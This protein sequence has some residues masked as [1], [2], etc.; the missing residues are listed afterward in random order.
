MANADECEDVHYSAPLVPTNPY[1]GGGSGGGGGDGGTCDCDPT[2]GSYPTST[3]LSTDINGTTQVTLASCSGLSSSDV[4]L[5]ETLIY[6]GNGTVGRVIA[7]NSGKLTV[8][9]MTTAGDGAGSKSD[10]SY[11][12]TSTL[13]TAFTGTTN[14][15]QSSVTGLSPA[16]VVLNETLIFDGNGTVG[17]VIGISGSNYIVQT[18]SISPGER[19]GTRLGSVEK[20]TNLPT[21]CAAAVSL[22]WQT[23]ISGDFAYVR[24]YNGHLAEFVAT[25]DDSCNITWQWS[26]DLNAGDYLTGVKDQKGNPLPIDGDGMVTLPRE[27]DGTYHSNTALN[28]AIGGTRNIA[29]SA[30]DIAAVGD[31]VLDETLI[32]DD[33]GTVG[34]V[35]AVSGT[36][37]T[38][39]TITVAGDGDASDGSYPTTATLDL[40]IA[41][42]TTIG[43]GTISGIPPIAD[44]VLNETL[45]YDAAGTLGRV[46]SVNASANTV[47]VETMTTAG[48]QDTVSDG[49]YATT[50]TLDKTIGNTQTLNLSDTAIANASDIMPGETLLFDAKGTMARVDSISGTGVITATTV[51]TAGVSDGTYNTSD[52]LENKVGDVKTISASNIT[53]ISLTDVVIG[54]TL[55][56]DNYG[57]VGKVVAVNTAA[58]TVDVETITIGVGATTN[59]LVGGWFYAEGQDISYAGGEGGSSNDGKANYWML[60]A[61]AL[62]DH[63]GTLRTAAMTVDGN[64]GQSSSNPDITVVELPGPALYKVD[65]TM[66]GSYGTTDS[67]AKVF[68]SENGSVWKFTGV[69]CKATGGANSMKKENQGSTQVFIEVPAGK[70]YYVGYA[71]TRAGGQCLIGKCSFSVHQISGTKFLGDSTNSNKIYI[72]NAIGGSNAPGGATEAATV[73]GTTSVRLIGTALSGH[74]WGGSEAQYG[75][76]SMVTTHGVKINQSGF[77]AI[78]GQIFAGGDWAANDGL[79]V[80][81]AGSSTWRYLDWTPNS[82]SVTGG[83]R[84]F[85][86][87]V[88]YLDAGDEVSLATGVFQGSA[89][90]YGGGELTVALISGGSPAELMMKPNLWTPN[91]EIDFGDGVYGYRMKGDSLYNDIQTHNTTIGGNTYN[92]TKFTGIQNVTGILNFGGSYNPGSLGNFRHLVPV[93]STTCLGGAS[94]AQSALPAIAQDNAELFWHSGYG[95]SCDGIGNTEPSPYDLWVIYTK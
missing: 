84:S 12:T 51:T 73:D 53:G 13:T 48:S 15:P 66:C 80:K 35:T 45:I 29:L 20:Q 81:D 44:I 77:Y 68:M 70:T 8:Q 28:T 47:T 39:K 4:V 60:Q 34:K 16:D 52:L 69:P 61:N 94:Q 23:P 65:A 25:V 91:T 5:K 31:I 30:T 24:D 74:S 33:D 67:E 10:G 42:S 3:T 95:G 46:V 14:V 92:Q 64:V 37:L 88:T 76:A 78:G 57:R 21:S 7:M 59:G 17:R 63:Y 58:G 49:T 82:K 75:D 40:T 83:A 62:H 85:N 2:S 27:S 22:G 43:Y 36:T 89:A 86:T 87:Q 55:V 6:D 72:V 11:L 19:S 32:F 79:V 56:N 50:K 1:G 54:E 9:T 90:G 71:L 41:N 93:G 38:V 18:M 26:H